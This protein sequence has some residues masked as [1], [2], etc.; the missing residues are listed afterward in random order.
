[1]PLDAEKIALAVANGLSIVCSTCENY[2]K[3]RDMGVPN[4]RCLAQ[5]GCGS[6]IAGDVFHEYK[7]PM[8]QFD[9]FCFVCGMKATHA[10]RVDRY[11]RV[12]GICSDHVSMVKRLK[13]EGKRAPNVVL[14]SK[15]GE[16]EIREDDAPE[17]PMIRLRSSDG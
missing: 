10:V 2:W 5:D 9:R 8:T 17:K 16:T 14:I 6:P 11:V 1:M 15:D 12:V 3:A 7:G 13:P 4:N